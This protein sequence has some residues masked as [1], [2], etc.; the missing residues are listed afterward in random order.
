MKG[1]TTKGLLPVQTYLSGMNLAPEQL[2]GYRKSKLLSAKGCDSIVYTE[3]E[4]DTR[5]SL[6]SS[7]VA[8]YKSLPEW[9]EASL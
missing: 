7:E 5:Y 3:G 8:F 9:N 6:S 2:D 4:R 1:R